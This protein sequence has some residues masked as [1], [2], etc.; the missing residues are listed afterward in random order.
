MR[1][2]TATDFYNYTKC[3]YR[4]YR[5]KNTSHSLHED[6]GYFMELIWQNGV[7]HEEDAVTYFKDNTDEKTFVDM[8]LHDDNDVA[9]V[10]RQ[11]SLH[12]KNGIDYIYQGVLADLG[13]QTLFDSSIDHIGRPDILMKVPISSKLGSHSYVPVD[14]K[15][16]AGMDETPWGTRFNPSYKMQLTFY[17]FLLEKQLG[18]PI[19]NGYIFDAKKELV[20][21]PLDTSA[22][23]FSDAFTE[24]ENMYRGST[25]GREEVISSVCGLCPWKSVCRKDAETK[26]NLSLLFYLGEKVKDGFAYIGINDMSALAGSDEQELLVN[27][28]TAKQQ[29]YFYKSLSDD[30]IKRLRVR[31]KLY[32][33]AQENEGTAFCI[34]YGEPLFPLTDKEIHYDIEDDPMGGVVY[35]HGFWII[36]KGKEPHYESIT[37]TKGKTEEGVSKELWAFFK[38]HAGT[39]IY[40]YSGHEKH[41]CQSLMKEYSLDRAVY[42]KVF[43]PEGSAIDL[44]DWVVENTDWPLSSY[45]LKPIAKYTGFEWSAEDAGGAN[46]IAW[47][48][49]YL[50][51]DD[52]KMQKILTYNEE[53]CKATA[54]IKNWFIEWFRING[55]VEKK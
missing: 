8:S 49:D 52:M 41:V 37:M 7:A 43:G 26:G 1:S 30:L 36:E 20:K 22:K 12:M 4:V 54:H 3:K 14:I 33:E 45:G 10:A 42:E 19:I 46:S 17:A 18:H 15:A 31:A 16:G 47:Y 13:S 5:D 23:D 27:V 21:Y 35:M 9:S 44:Y 50:A 24:I 51:G 40:H 34:M 25:S 2:I 6:V 32:L 29:G 39:P 28:R 48:Y 11:T 55:T 53:D 38:R